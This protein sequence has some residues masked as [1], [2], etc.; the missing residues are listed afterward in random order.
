MFYYDSRGL[1]DT[2]TFSWYSTT[3]RIDLGN[4]ETR[5][6][7]AAGAIFIS[8]IKTSVTV[9]EDNW[10]KSC[11]SADGLR[12]LNGVKLV[13]CP[14]TNARLTVSDRILLQEIHH[15]YVG[16]PSPLLHKGVAMGHLA[17]AGTS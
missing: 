2:L 6:A 15:V 12:L 1:I 3:S 17:A 10:E 7:F 8:S 16:D 5:Y 4:P 13:N 9:L 14:C 11:I